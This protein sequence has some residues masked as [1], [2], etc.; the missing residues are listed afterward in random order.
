MR[1]RINELFDTLDLVAERFPVL[2]RLLL[3]F[4]LFVLACVGAYSLLTRHH[5]ILPRLRYE[6]A[7]A[8][9]AMEIF[10]GAGY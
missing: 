1:K 2:H 9:V 10:M 6:Q 7:D 4:A 8:V 3:E 5:E